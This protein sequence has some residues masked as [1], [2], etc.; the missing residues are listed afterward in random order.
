[1]TGNQRDRVFWTQYPHAVSEQ[2]LQRN[3][4]TSRIPSHSPYM[5]NA[6]ARGQR[7]RVFWTQYP[8]AVSEQFRRVNGIHRTAGHTLPV[9]KI[10]TNDQSMRVIRT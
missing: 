5:R 2:F 7:V 3:N 1:M 9:C 6:P 10:V 8:H 4:R